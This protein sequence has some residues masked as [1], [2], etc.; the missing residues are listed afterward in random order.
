MIRMSSLAAKFHEAFVAAKHDDHFPLATLAPTS[1]VFGV[2]DSRSTYVKLQR[3]LK[4]YI[5][6]T[7]VQLRSRSAQFT[8]AVD[9]IAA[10]GA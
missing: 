6:A 1:L 9:Y 4:G 2:W 8:P 3:I 10:G 7:N 5:R